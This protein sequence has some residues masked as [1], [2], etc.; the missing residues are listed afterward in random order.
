MSLIC[1]L[2]GG[3]TKPIASSD[4]NHRVHKCPV[5]LILHDNDPNEGGTFHADPTRR[6]R[7]EEERIEVEKDRIRS[8]RLANTNHKRFKRER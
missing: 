4:P 7:E 5:C 1:P 8:R 3:P 6:L 2:C